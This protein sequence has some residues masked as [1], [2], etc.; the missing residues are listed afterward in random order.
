MKYFIHQ[1]LVH[2][3]LPGYNNNYYSSK[4]FQVGHSYFAEHNICQ[5]MASKA[6]VPFLGCLGLQLG[7]GEGSGF[8][9]IYIKGTCKSCKSIKSTNISQRS[10]AK[11]CTKRKNGL[12]GCISQKLIFK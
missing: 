6:S 11:L 5:L 12:L 10:P 2:T 4:A 3:V 1:T 8:H 9:I 7:W